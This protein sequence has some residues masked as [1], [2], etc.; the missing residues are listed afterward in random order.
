M[1]TKTFVLGGALAIVF[2]VGPATS[3]P[4]TTEIDAL[5]KT[6]AAKDAGTGPTSGASGLTQSGTAAGKEHPPTARDEPG[7]ARP[8]DLT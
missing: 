4:C 3:G 8:G 7:H 6:L 2:G 5:A 1:K